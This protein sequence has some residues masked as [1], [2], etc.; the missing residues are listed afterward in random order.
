[1]LRTVKT[2]EHHVILRDDV[3]FL[4]EHFHATMDKVTQLKAHVDWLMEQL[5][6]DDPSFVSEDEPGDTP[7]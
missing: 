3:N 5:D 1:M 7:H 6:K 4:Q 2:R